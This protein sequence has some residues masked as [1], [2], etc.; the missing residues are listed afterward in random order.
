M[1]ARYNREEKRAEGEKGKEAWREREVTWCTKGSKSSGDARAIPST[2]ASSESLWAPQKVV[3]TSNNA[4]RN[5]L[6]WY[7]RLRVKWGG[8]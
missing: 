5:G 8:G 7:L 4:G 6:M 2:K 3:T 1:G